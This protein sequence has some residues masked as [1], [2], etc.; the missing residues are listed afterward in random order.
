MGGLCLVR[1]TG[2]GSFFIVPCHSPPDSGTFCLCRL[3][4]R[5]LL[6]HLARRR[7][8]WQASLCLFGLVVAL[9]TSVAE[10]VDAGPLCLAR[11]FCF[12]VLFMGNRGPQIGLYHRI[13]SFPLLFAANAGHGYLS[14]RDP[15]YWTCSS[16]LKRR[17]IYL[18]LDASTTGT[19]VLLQFCISKPI[20]NLKSQFA[21][22]KLQRIPRRWESQ[23]YPRP[24]THTLRICCFSPVFRPCLVPIR[25]FAVGE[26][27][28]PSTIQ[29][30]LP[31]SHPYF[32]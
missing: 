16:R 5:P 3:V 21:S 14:P 30:L 27:A 2:T 23:S 22:L 28:E 32:P 6:L 31:V 29:S 9:A 15:G 17:N 26:A 11:L 25:S 18:Q 1:S 12:V 24:F 4:R 8:G 7:G 10:A 13:F 20:S 19:L